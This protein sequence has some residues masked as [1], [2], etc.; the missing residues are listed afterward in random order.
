MKIIKTA[1]GKKIK[2]SKKEWESIGKTAGWAKEASNDLLSYDGVI[3]LG[4]KLSSKRYDCTTKLSSAIVDLFELKDS[5]RDNPEW[6]DVHEEVID[7]INKLGGMSNEIKI[8]IG[9]VLQKMYHKY[10]TH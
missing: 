1:S 5:T 9:G 2:M 3:S 10:N 8:T 4:D 7:A 6:A